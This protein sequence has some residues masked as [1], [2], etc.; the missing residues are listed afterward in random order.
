MDE[1]Y[2]S[3]MMKKNRSLKEFLSV[4]TQLN[5]SNMDFLTDKCEE[6]RRPDVWHNY[7]KEIKQ[8]QELINSFDFGEKENPDASRSSTSRTTWIKAST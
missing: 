2:H 8:I 1:K 3:R 7:D 6:I 4:L 5:I